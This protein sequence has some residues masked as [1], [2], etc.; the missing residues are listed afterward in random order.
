MN[1]IHK[2][3][4][5]FIIVFSV[6]VLLFG[7]VGSVA[8]LS[9]HS[10]AEL[11]GEQH[12]SSPNPA[13]TMSN[14]ANNT[15]HTN[16][17]SKINTSISFDDAVSALAL[18]N[19]SSILSTLDKSQKSSIASTGDTPILYNGSVHHVHSD[20]K[21][22]LPDHLSQDSKVGTAGSASPQSDNR[23]LRKSLNSGIIDPDTR[24]RITADDGLTSFPYAPVVELQIITKDDRR[25]LC[26]GVIVS[27]EDLDEH[28][29]HVLTAG[30]CVHLSNQGGWIDIS[31]SSVDGDPASRVVP[32]ANAGEQPFGAVAITDIRTYEGWIDQQDPAYDL[33]LLT[34][35][36]RIGEQTGSLGYIAADSDD[37]VYSHSPSRIVGYPSDKPV[38]TMWTSVGTGL[39]TMSQSYQGN[40]LLH[41]HDMDMFQG[42]SGGPVWIEDDPQYEQPRV[43]SI[44]AY[45]VDRDRD[46]ETEYNV[47]P[48]LTNRRVGDIQNWM[49]TDDQYQPENDQYE[50]NDNFDEASIIEPSTTIP[51]LQIVR[52]EKDYFA[53][54]LSEGQKFEATLT[55]SQTT[56]NIDLAVY[57]PDRQLL[58]SSNTRTDG[59]TITIKS[60]DTTGKHYIVA[61]GTDDGTTVPYQLETTVTTP[62][63]YGAV[64]GNVTTAD[65]TAVSNATVRILKI[66]TEEAVTTTTTDPSGEY[67]F[68]EIETGHYVVEAESQGYLGRSAE[69]RITSGATTTVDIVIPELTADPEQKIQL[70]SDVPAQ[71]EPGES[72]TISY[73]LRNINLPNAGGGVISINVSSP[74]SVVSDQTKF[75]GIQS[76]PPA[77]GENITKSFT[78]QASTNTTSS[79]ATI[80]ASAKLQ[81]VDE[82]LQTNISQQLIVSENSSDRF[83]TNDEPGIQ[84]REVISAIVAYNS[85]R[86]LGGQPV[87]SQDIIDLIVRYNN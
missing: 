42:M 13:E 34:L 17:T 81:S 37:P 41:K 5:S 1:P 18:Q 67:T 47:G 25:A 77:V 6:G 79:N 82:R 30:H 10:S 83:D 86:P 14:W 21:Q 39:E 7:C 28:S 19:A 45:A 46:G 44:N 49:A 40:N 48:R 43:V 51:D 80:F 70:D 68:S 75:I 15:T 22:D 31:P 54:E 71:I 59:E 60:I 20:T 27:E 38:H 55:F 87:T 62:T 66:P 76:P 72:V 8:A 3:P 50:P 29:Y 11:A 78:I 35:D 63:E 74:I 58:R 12:G 65:G 61:E 64:S 16:K 9:A 57:G 33:A 23:S 36:R 73:T 26:S 53:V 84:S 24:S 32:A 2:Y 52:D 69:T 4:S 56:G 85:G